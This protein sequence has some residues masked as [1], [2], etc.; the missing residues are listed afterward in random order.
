MEEEDE[1]LRELAAIAKGS[2]IKEGRKRAIL[3]LARYG[4]K[5]IPV[6]TEVVEGT[7]FQDTKELC[8][9]VIRSIKERPA[10]ETRTGATT[11]S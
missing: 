10:A 4:K 3:E 6:L 5:A 7:V 2:T 8:L 1:W 11:G 9:E